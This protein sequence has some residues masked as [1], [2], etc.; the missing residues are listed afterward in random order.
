LEAERR[1][2]LVEEEKAKKKIKAASV[3][4]DEYDDDD[5]ENANEN[6]EQSQIPSKTTNRSKMTK[7][8]QIAA[9]I[10]EKETKQETNRS[11]E[12]KIDRRENGY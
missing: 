12:K 5:N 1:K 7:I 3:G 9:S 4:V 11:A 2:E 6:N 8:K 10:N